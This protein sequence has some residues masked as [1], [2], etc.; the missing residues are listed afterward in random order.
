[1]DKRSNLLWKGVTYDRKKFYNIDHGQTVGSL[2]ANKASRE[3]DLSA[4]L[5]LFNELENLI[6]SNIIFFLISKVKLCLPQWKL[7]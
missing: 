5:N 3:N 4:D 2:L 6:S 1:M 7:F